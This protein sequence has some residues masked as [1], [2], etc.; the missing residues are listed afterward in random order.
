MG[1]QKPCR[2]IS[3]RRARGFR[4]WY[5]SRKISSRKF[6]RLGVID[7]DCTPHSSIFINDLI[8]I[9]DPSDAKR[10]FPTWSQLV[11]MLRRGCH[12]IYEASFLI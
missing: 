8:L 4:S 7:M 3:K 1:P 10:A 9:E 11:R 6:G 2:K 5:G 12:S